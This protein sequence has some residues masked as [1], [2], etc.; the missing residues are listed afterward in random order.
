MMSPFVV[1]SFHSPLRVRVDRRD[2]G[3][4]VDLGASRAGALPQR[5]REVGGRDVPVMRVVER[6][7]DRGRVGRAAELEQR[8]QLLHFASAR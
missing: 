2:F 1:V 7:D 8:P 5:H 6:A 4:L 3:L